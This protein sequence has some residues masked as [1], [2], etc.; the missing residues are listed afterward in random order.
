MASSRHQKAETLLSSPRAVF[1]KAGSA[2]RAELKG[3]SIA[4]LA[5][6]A[7]VKTTPQRRAAFA[8]WLEQKL[9]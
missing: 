8:E 6:A 2:W 4:E 1:N 9:A 5:R 3:E 7:R